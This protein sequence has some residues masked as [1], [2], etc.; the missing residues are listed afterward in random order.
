MEAPQQPTGLCSLTKRIL[1]LEETLKELNVHRD[2]SDAVN[3]I[4]QS[5]TRKK[6]KRTRSEVEKIFSHYTKGLYKHL[7][8]GVFVDQLLLVLKYS[9]LYIESNVSKFSLAMDC[10]I[11]GVFKLDTCMSLVNSIADI[12]DVYSTSMLEN[13]INFL[14]KLM[15]NSQTILDNIPPPTTEP[16]ASLKRRKSVCSRMSSKS[17]EHAE[18]SNLLPEHHPKGKK[19]LGKYLLQNSKGK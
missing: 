4:V 6:E 16:P 17:I 19:T 18:L 10:E 5:N 9:I 8:K 12:R 13:C 14:V 1:E 2:E 3:D 7:D 15:Y 11:T